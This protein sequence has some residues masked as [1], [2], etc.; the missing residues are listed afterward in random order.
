[1]AEGDVYQVVHVQSYRGQQILNVYFYRQAAPILVGDIAQ[2]MA[3]TFESEVVP[4][5]AAVQ[6]DDL[7]H[8]ELRVTNLFNP[9]EEATSPLAGTGAITGTDTQASFDAVGF[10]L[11]QDNGAL[12]NGSKRIGGIPS[13]ADTDGVIDTPTYVTALI[14]LGTA[15][16]LGL[17]AGIVSNA[18][19]PVIVGR[20]L[21]GGSYR[22]PENAGEAVLGNI[23]EAVFN[24]NT[25][26]QTSRK[27]GR[28]V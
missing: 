25:T 24:A 13:D 17:D 26:S 21:D 1:M 11:N 28:G 27:I 20:I 9:A 8:I 14:A 22:L 5:V 19:I 15:M 23:L 6:T 3:D 2:Q 7:D 10:R 12:R 4:A 16:A 18:F